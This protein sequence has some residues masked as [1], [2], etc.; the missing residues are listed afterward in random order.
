MFLVSG[1][2]FL[3]PAFDKYS[4]LA[5]YITGG[6]IILSLLAVGI[7][8]PVFEEILFRGLIFGELRKITRVRAALFIQAVLFGIYHLDIIQ[9]S[10]AFL[11]GIL[12]GYVYYRS[13]SIVAPMIVHATINTTSV[14]LSRVVPGGGLDE[15]S[16][17]IVA[18]SVILFIASSA[19]ILISRS[20]RHVMDNSFYEMNKTP[21]LEPPLPP[22]A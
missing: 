17:A 5:Q 10:Y 12:L 13:N 4:E 16:A 3:A 6:D 15:W 14:I 11:I 21:R 7:I 19:F 18:A 20:F 9:G 22:T 1:L 2:D 8:G